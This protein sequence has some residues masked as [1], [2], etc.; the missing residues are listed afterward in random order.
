MG[1]RLFGYEIKK[2]VLSPVIVGFVALCIIF[3]IVLTISAYDNYETNYNAEAIN[4]YED[5]Q[6]NEIAESYIWKYN[7]TGKNAENI[8]NKYEKLQPVIDEKSANGDALSAYFGQQTHYRHSLLFE[9][10][11]M[12]IIS[13]SCLLA[14]FATL[15]SVT[16]ENMQGTEHIIY[17]SKIGRRQLKTKLGASLMVAVVLTAVILGMSLCIFFLRFDFSG[18]C[19]D[20]VSSMFN[21]AVS[22]YGKPFITWH[23]LT[24]T[25]YLG[26]TIGV[27]FGLVICFCLVGY[28]AG[29][30]ARNGYG[31]FIGAASVIGATFLAKPLF[32]IGSIS[33]SIL[34]LTPVWLWENSGAWFTDGGADIIW[35]NFESMGLLFS[36]VVLSTV[37]FIAAKIFNKRELL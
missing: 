9:I 1:Y 11:F 37:A 23:S 22:E 17:A 35:A 7:I 25:G 3:N 29:V 19:K 30:F 20:N 12:A 36:L 4:I 32:P 34:N 16:Y 27:T 13:E 24:V 6:A 28:A 15:V 26:A 8:R 21:Y 10:I 5:F 33:R 2:L 18:V 31:A 14:L